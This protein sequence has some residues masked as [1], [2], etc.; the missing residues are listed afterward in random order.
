MNEEASVKAILAW[1]F[2]SV[3][4]AFIFWLFGNFIVWEFSAPGVM[5]RIFTIIGSVVWAGICVA[6]YHNG[7]FDD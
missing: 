7:V 6:G 4:T 2:L 1:I 5:T 3:L